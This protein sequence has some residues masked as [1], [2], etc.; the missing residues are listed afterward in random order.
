MT[1]V[2]RF[3]Y[4][5]AKH[6]QRKAHMVYANNFSEGNLTFCGKFVQKGWNFVVG[7]PE[8]RQICNLCRDS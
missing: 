3:Y 5:H 2:K 7:K 8:N 1:Q 6:R 4:V